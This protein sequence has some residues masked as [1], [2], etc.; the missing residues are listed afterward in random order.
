MNRKLLIMTHALAGGGAERVLVVLASE[1]ARRGASVTFAVASED[2]ANRPF[3]DAAV[4][5]VTIRTG[6]GGLIDLVR[7]LRAG[8]FDASLSAIGGPNLK[9]ILA[10]LLAGRARRAVQSVHGFLEDE[11]RL[12]NQLGNRLMG[13]TAALS[14]R[15]VT[16]S[17]ALEENVRRRFHV[18]ARRLVTIH[19]P[20]FVGGTEEAAPPL[21]GRAPVILFMGR[22][23]PPKRPWD[24]LDILSRLKT[25]GARLVILG[26]GPLLPELRAQAERLGI[27]GRVT[28]AGYVREPWAL[29]HE[30]RLLLLTSQRETFGNVLVEALAHGLPVVATRCGGPA[31]I[32]TDAGLGRLVDIGD[33]EGAARAVDALLAD[34]GDPAPRR[35]R[36]A[37]FDVSRGVD[38]YEAL[39]ETVIAESE[40]GPGR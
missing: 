22:L 9:H 37:Q 39:I 12:L 19:N 3:L 16:V 27:A 31:E 14:G 8:G 35:A 29:L 2:G 18:P 5:L 28:F 21:L 33:V 6:F 24:A 4:E 38:A 25:P 40:G 32:V 34:P 17:H 7:M 11:P 20:I 36:A 30:A 15:T 26:D 13:V 10:A 23:V 1:L